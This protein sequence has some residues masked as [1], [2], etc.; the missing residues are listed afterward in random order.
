MRVAASEQWQFRLL[1]F[2]IV[3]A[4]SGVSG[5]RCLAGAEP[6]QS[7]SAN[8]DRETG[9]TVDLTALSGEEL[10]DA[11]L[12][13]DTQRAAH[14]ELCRRAKFRTLDPPQVHENGPPGIEV[15]VCPQG[16]DRAPLY[17]VI[18]PLYADSPIL[19]GGPY[20]VLRPRELFG[21]AA[22]YLRHDRVTMHCFTRQGR[23]ID[24]FP[25][26]M[27]PLF[28][29]VMTD[30]NGD[31]IVERLW[32]EWGSI[33]GVE[34]TDVLRIA[35]VRREPEPLLCVLYNWRRQE[36][37]G[38]QVTDR[39]G[40]GLAEI[41]LGPV[42][43]EWIRP[44]V[45]Y[46]WDPDRGAYTGPEGRE[47]DHFRRIDPARVSEELKR[48]RDEGLSFPREADP[49]KAGRQADGKS[50][51]ASSA[52]ERWRFEF[53][54]PGH[55]TRVCED[56]WQRKPKSAA[57]A[58]VQANRNDIHHKFFAIAVDDR[59]SDRPPAVCSMLFHYWGGAMITG[60]EPRTF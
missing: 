21:P 58:T 11:L 24:P 47:G 31:G 5:P 33:S 14:A 46:R 35:T 34:A 37:W 55:P 57:L 1:C 48:L 49:T 19:P 32:R 38:Y 9:R 25:Q 6:G 26:D 36:E 7:P 22:E 50:P 59:G 41:E 3:L 13:A 44:E 4:I 53:L 12:K 29:V 60:R 45:T 20:Y 2:F 28:G 16:E 17:A 10:I 43:D 15:V 51:D 27:F 40:D 42:T 30:L 8:E 52:A 39:N 56:F 23:W 18:Y 54:R